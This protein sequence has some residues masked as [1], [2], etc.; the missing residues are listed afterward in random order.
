VLK[1]RWS[2]AADRQQGGSA[3]NPVF[4]RKQHLIKAAT[5]YLQAFVPQQVHASWDEFGR[6]LLR[7]LHT[8]FD[9]EI[10]EGLRD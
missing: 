1:Y 4:S 10:C 5:T 2:G 6:T 7:G 3:E 9:A 8:E